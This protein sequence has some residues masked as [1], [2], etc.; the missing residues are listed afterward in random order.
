M[1]CQLRRKFGESVFDR[2]DE[3]YA[4]SNVEQAQDLR[5]LKNSI[6]YVVHPKHMPP[7]RPFIFCWIIFKW[8]STN[9]QSL[10]VTVKLE[11]IWWAFEY[12]ILKTNIRQSN[13]GVAN[14]KYR[15]DLFIHILGTTAASCS[16]SRK[17]IAAFRRCWHCGN[18]SETAWERCRS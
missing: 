1:A 5:H 13:I 11:Y 14:D 7:R 3:V 12:S 9:I 6:V 18:D 4:D 15:D 16:R 2:D 8:H 17:D 10:V